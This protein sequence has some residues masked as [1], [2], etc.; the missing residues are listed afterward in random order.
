MDTTVLK[1]AGLTDAEARVYL[2]LLDL[3]SAKIGA[4]VKKSKV[5]QSKIYD[6]LSRLLEKGLAS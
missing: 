4:L 2:A 5:A 6:V 1:Q 3:G